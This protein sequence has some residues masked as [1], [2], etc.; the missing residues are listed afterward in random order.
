MIVVAIIGVLAALAIYG[1]RKYLLHSKTAEATQAVGR[2]A[3]GAA[4]AFDRDLMAGDVV[5][6]SDTANVA[7]RLCQSAASPVPSTSTS[8]QGKKYQSSPSEWNVAGW[9]C[10]KFTMTDP[11]YYMYDYVSSGTTGDEGDTFTA[12]ANGDLNADGVLSTFTLTGE[13][14]LG[15]RLGKLVTIAP[16]LQTTLPEE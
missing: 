8:I 12:I 3:K 11:Q 10:I 6:L 16:N 1:V 14:Q 9:T 15:S 5:P 2:M 7:H 4:A 13:I